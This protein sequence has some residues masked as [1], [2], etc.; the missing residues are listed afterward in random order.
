MAAIATTQTLKYSLKEFTDVSFSGFEYEIPSEICT[1]I[2]QLCSHVGVLGLKKNT[3]TKQIE[4]SDSTVGVNGF[5]ILKQSSSIGGKKRKGNKSQEVS[6]EEWESIRTFQAT[7]I[8]QKTGIEGEM[9][10]VRLLLN[11][12]TDKTFLDIR[13]QL[14]EKLNYIHSN[15]AKDELLLLGTMIYDVSCANKFYS[16]IFADLFSEIYTLYEWIQIPFNSILETIM[17]KYTNITYVDPNVDY[18]GFCAMNKTNDQRKSVSA[19]LVNLA[20]N[21]VI[22]KQRVVDLLRQLLLLVKHMIVEPNKANEVAEFTEN[23]AIL[24]NCDILKSREVDISI[25]ELSKG[26][27]II[28]GVHEIAKYKTKDYVSLSNKTVFKFMDLAD[29][30]MK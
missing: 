6:A 26:D 30:K 15:F 2:N 23:I 13:E 4:P 25:T 20:I 9:V 10:Q 1:I 12:L 21:G 27:T 18:D 8:E 22:S 24:Y 19:F 16:K 5:G 7:K 29:I 17:D 14:L 3:F 11:K 28:S